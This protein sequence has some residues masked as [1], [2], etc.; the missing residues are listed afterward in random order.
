MSD[1][2]VIQSSRVAVQGNSVALH[3]AGGSALSVSNQASGAASAQFELA[4]STRFVTVKA[5]G[6]AMAIEIGTNP[7]ATAASIN[8]ADG[9]AFSFAVTPGAGMKVAVIDL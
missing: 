3:D 8:L 2:T 6:G 9:E 4:D 7:T 1:L 5:R